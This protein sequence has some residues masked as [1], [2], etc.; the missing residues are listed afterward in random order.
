[1]V[2]VRDMEGKNCDEKVVGL[3][4]TGPNAGETIQ[5]FAV[6]LRYVRMGRKEGRIIQVHS[7]NKIDF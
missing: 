5:G 1:M 6:A 2:C 7:Q 3:H 4:L